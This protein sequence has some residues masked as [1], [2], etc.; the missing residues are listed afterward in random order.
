VAQKSKGFVSST[1]RVDNLQNVAI[2]EYRSENGEVVQQYPTQSQIQAFRR[3]EHLQKVRE[4]ARAAEARA[5]AAPDAAKNL[6]DTTDG[7]AA[8][9]TQSILT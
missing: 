7:D 9:S 2:L 6:A 5:A 8:N 1:I 4:E 3:A